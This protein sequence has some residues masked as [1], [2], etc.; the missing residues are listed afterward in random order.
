MIITSARL[1]TTFE[2]AKACG[3]YHTTVINWINKGMLKARV[4]PG[5]H[6][7]VALPDLLEFMRRFEMPIPHD[8]TDRP[9]RVLIVEDDPAVQRLIKRTL[10]ELPSIDLQACDNGLQA[11]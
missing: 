11:L 7:R 10:S 4:T 9:K 5:G 6:R 2:T 1:F 3:A 8:L